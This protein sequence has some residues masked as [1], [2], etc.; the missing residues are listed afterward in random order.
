MITLADLLNQNTDF[1]RVWKNEQK[2]SHSRICGIIMYT[3]AH[4]YV[5]EV[6]ANSHAWDAL[7]EIS[8]S[9]WPIY[10]IRPEPV[11]SHT[12]VRGRMYQMVRTGIDPNDNTKF[13]KF[14]NLQQ[15]NLPCFVVFAW[16]DQGELEYF[17]WKIIDRPDP[18][19]FDSITK[20]IEIINRAEQDVGP[21]NATGMNL[22][23]RVEYLCQIEE[24]KENGLKLLKGLKQG[25]PIAR[26]AVNSFVQ[27][28]F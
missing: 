26:E 2:Q 4:R 12:P 16:N 5:S 25:I 1:E 15:R 22:Y 9:N 14:F 6:L 10:A 18:Q 3:R 20:I 11:P 13:L 27:S 19:A 21:E 7:D 23:N 17:T 28:F 8:G 24:D